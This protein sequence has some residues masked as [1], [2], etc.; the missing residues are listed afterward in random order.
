MT[1]E[2]R[3]SRYFE[4]IKSGKFRPLRDLAEEIRRRLREEKVEPLD[5]IEEK[6]DEEVEVPKTKSWLTMFKEWFMKFIGF[7]NGV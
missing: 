4:D 7:K 1:E 5:E 2:E 3:M 6:K